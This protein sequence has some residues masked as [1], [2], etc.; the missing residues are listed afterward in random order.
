M[1]KTLEENF[2]YSKLGK[3]FIHLTNMLV[4]KRRHFGVKLHVKRVLT[5]LS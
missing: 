3:E 4:K 1:S 2:D 5:V